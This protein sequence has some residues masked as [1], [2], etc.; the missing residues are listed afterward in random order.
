[1]SRRHR[2]FTFPVSARFMENNFLAGYTPQRIT[3]LNN[4]IGRELV[5]RYAEWIF[6]ASKTRHKSARR[7]GA[8]PTG[9]LEFSRSCPAHTR[10]GGKIWYRVQ[11]KVAEIIIQG[12]AG[13]ARAFGALD[14][15]PRKAKALTI[16][17]DREAYA[18]TAAKMEAKGWYLFVPNRKFERRNESAARGCL[19]GKKGGITKPLFAL[20]KHTH[21]KHDKGLMP[22]DRIVENWTR[23]ASEEYLEAVGL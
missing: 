15:V 16:P 23:K 17:I 14:I 1:M 11:N 3:A 2:I 6:N 9:V 18:Q 4:H 12:V 21:I 10:R 8:Q 22:T 13:L 20:R 5:K 19:W 7:L